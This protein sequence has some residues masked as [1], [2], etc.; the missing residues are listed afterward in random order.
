ML[1]L[2][3]GA[4]VLSLPRTSS[5]LVH[6][7]YLT[8]ADYDLVISKDTDIYDE[9][10]GERVLYFRKGNSPLPEFREIKDLL[11]SYP[12]GVDEA[13]FNSDLPALTVGEFNVLIK[14]C[15]NIYRSK[16][17]IFKE[18]RDN[19]EPSHRL[20]DFN[21]YDPDRFLKYLENDLPDEWSPEWPE[22]F[23]NYKR[24]H[25]LSTGWRSY[26]R[27]LLLN[28]QDFKSCGI[29]SDFREFV[30]K[31]YSPDEPL[32]LGFNY[33]YRLFNHVDG[34]LGTN[35][36]ITVSENR[37]KNWLGS[38]LVFPEYRV[39]FDIREGDTLVSNTGKLLHGNTL[40]RGFGERI[41]LVVFPGI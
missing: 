8:E 18:L 13:S 4:D 23:K 3:G 16:E 41:S 31:F 32:S 35:T 24:H 28:D 1:E 39:A 27:Y 38:E 14:G 30:D 29:L 25:L 17:E 5:N 20:W 21:Q 12:L 7:I 10:T 34:Y 19:P 11:Y 26:R 36:V 40:K 33:N 2:F 15:H 6:G 9:E 22:F 37:S